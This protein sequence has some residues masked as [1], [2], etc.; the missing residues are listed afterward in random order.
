ME[1]VKV[2]IELFE[3]LVTIRR[4][5]HQHPELSFK[6]YATCEYITRVLEEWD[7]PYNRISET[8]I[9]VDIIGRNKKGPYIGIRADIDALPIQ[10]QTGLPFS[11]VNQG[12]MHACGH[13][14]HTT[15]LLGTVYQLHRL[16]DKFSG[17]VRCIFQPG[18]EADGAAQQL[19]DLGVLENPSIDAMLALHL[20][21]HLPHGTIGIKY[22]AITASCDDFTIEIVGKSGH[23]ARPHQAI[24]AITI[25]TQILQALHILVTKSSNPVEPV[26]VHIGKINGGTAS[27]IVADKV[28]LEGTTRAVTFETREKLK[29]QLIDLCES[30]AK[31]FGGKATVHYK[32]GHPPVINS[33]WVTRTVEESAI[34]L[35]GP[36]KVV[37]L[38]EPSMG[39]DDFG[40]F[41]QIVPSTYFR[42]GTALEEKKAFDLHHPQFEFDESIIPIG[43]Q[44]FTSTVLNKL[45]RGV[46]EKC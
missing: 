18:E 39:A 7:I 10:E 21:P 12:V 23:S 30:I 45:S 40:A 16:R 3:Q 32:D 44:L 38:K 5:L 8:G 25:S 46:E 26:V 15:I 19:I 31:N 20:W 37:Y 6:E 36:E 28:V 11:S 4:H 24:D 29:S 41:A 14:G 43:V 13:D 42:L 9:Y 34:E 17:R 27:N 2:S 35:F 22:G 33:D 1:I